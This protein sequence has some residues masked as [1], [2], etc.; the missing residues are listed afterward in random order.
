MRYRAVDHREGHRWELRFEASDLG[1]G[2]RHLINA[3]F[4]HI[5]KHQQCQHEDSSDVWVICGMKRGRNVAWLKCTVR[6][7]VLLPWNRRPGC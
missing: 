7:R 3:P 4:A 6:M 2:R 5:P 1:I